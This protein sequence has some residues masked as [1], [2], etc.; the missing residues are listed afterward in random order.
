MTY[1]PATALEVEAE[2]MVQTNEINF[3][4]FGRL[5]ERKGLEQTKPTLRAVEL[6]KS[7]GE[8]K[9]PEQTRP[10]LEFALALSDA[11]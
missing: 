6:K 2:G 3:E 4:E 9:R 10:T 1:A 7:P 5:V 8:W 11:G